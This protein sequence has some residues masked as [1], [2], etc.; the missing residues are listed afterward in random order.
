MYCLCSS[1]SGTGCEFYF[2]CSRK[3]SE[4]LQPKIS[5]YDFN[6]KNL[7]ILNY[8]L[9]NGYY[10]TK[11][12]KGKSV[13]F[14]IKQTQQLIVFGARMLTYIEKNTYTEHILELV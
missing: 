1:Q 8:C 10:G 13:L 7:I 14:N 3:L 4:S 2:N 11:M 6:C 5:S 9:L 12:D